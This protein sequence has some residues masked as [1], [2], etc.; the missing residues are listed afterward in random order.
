MEIVII[1]NSAAAVG[2]IEAIRRVNSVNPITVIS[3]E[4]YPVYS[5]PL[6]SYLL[7]GDIKYE[8]LF[9]RPKNFYE[10]HNVKTLLGKPVTKVNFQESKVELRDGEKIP[11]DRLL[12]ATGGTPFIPKI[13]GVRKSGVYTFT[14]LDDAKKILSILKE[15]QRAT[16]IG[17]GLIGLKVAEAL[18]KK[19]K[20]VT[21]IELANHILNFT[22]DETASTL[23]EK[24]LEKERIQ[25]RTSTTVE[26][27][28]GNGKVKALRL[29]NGETL[30][31]QL[32]ILAIGVIPNIEPF[33]GTPLQMDKGILVN[34]RMEANLPQLYAAGDVTQAYD[35]SLKI[36][37]PL[38]IW[39]NAYRQGKT[40]GY[41]MVGKEEYIYDGGFMMNSM[42]VAH[43]PVIS[44]GLTHLPSEDG[45]QVIKKIDR[46][47]NTYRK[48]V[49]KENQ[50]V[51]A[52]LIGK[53]DRAGIITGLIRDGLSVKEFKKELLK[54]SFG[55]ISFPKYLR[56]ERLWNQK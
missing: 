37:R 13:E 22:L 46:R 31:T 9:Y 27:I 35:K 17:G 39:P 51:G 55:L 5:R 23:L 54:E 8:Q 11:Y 32:V 41:Q 33:K 47:H 19:G 16:V 36:H 29:T 25:L 6:L 52:I 7:S 43:L 26:E 10:R 50:L 28:L 24:G 40:A 48:F 44:I 14:K 49:L 21:V 2:A 45:Y 4:P 18:K 15:V 12:I 1:G 53:I 30:E 38:P 20:K 34:E 42:E 3:E 56:K